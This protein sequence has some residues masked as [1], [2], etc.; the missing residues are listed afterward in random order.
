MSGTWCQNAWHQSDDAGPTYLPNVQCFDTIF[1]PLCSLLQLVVCAMYSGS[2]WGGWVYL[3]WRCGLLNKTSS[4]ICDN[5]YFPMCLLSDKSWTFIYIASLMALV[6][7]CDSLHGEIAQPHIMTW[8]DG[9]I[10][11]GKGALKCSFNLSQRVLAD[12][13][14]YSSSHSNLLHLYLLLVYYSISLCDVILVPRKP[15]GG[16]WWYCL[17]QNRP[18]ISF[19]HK[20]SWNFCLVP[21][22]KMPPYGCYCCWC[23]WCCHWNCS[24]PL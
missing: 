24:V 11:D 6:R 21:L 14:I 15:Q 3:S 10:I 23:Q 8:G 17:S 20:C 13:L 7:V 4:N 9:M 22:C 5:W 1:G 2:C 19:Y 16:F 12:S 18:G